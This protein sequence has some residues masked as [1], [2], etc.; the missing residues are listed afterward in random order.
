MLNTL[1]L[2]VSNFSI[3]LLHQSADSAAKGNPTAQFPRSGNFFSRACIPYLLLP[4]SIDSQ[5]ASF[6]FK[7]MNLFFFYL[8]LFPL[9]VATRPSPTQA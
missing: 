6:I 7:G 8:R 9:K 5:G 2:E 3:L 4:F 1:S